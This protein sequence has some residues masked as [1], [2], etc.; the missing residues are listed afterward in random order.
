MPLTGLYTQ[1]IRVVHDYLY[2]TYYVMI[3]LTSLSK[4]LYYV[5]H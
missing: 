3:T 4:S 5:T 1:V 2:E